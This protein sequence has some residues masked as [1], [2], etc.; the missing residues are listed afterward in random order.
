MGD[1]RK[2]PLDP[3]SAELAVPEVAQAWGVYVGALSKVRGSAPSL[4]WGDG[5]GLLWTG[6]KVAVA[7]EIAG[8]GSRGCRRERG[9][10][11]VPSSWDVIFSGMSPQGQQLVACIRS[12]KRTTAAKIGKALGLSSPQATAILRKVMSFEKRC[13][14][15]FPIQVVSGTGTGGGNPTQYTWVGKE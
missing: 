3:T 10:L 15:A 5:V 12:S 8:G 2:R 14:G 9:K 13:S 6:E 1:E 7:A 11:I 4:L